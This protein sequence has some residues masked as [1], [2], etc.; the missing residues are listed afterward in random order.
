MPIEHARQRSLAQLIRTAQHARIG[1]LS[2]GIEPELQQH[3]ARHA[4]A[5]RTAH[6]CAMRQNCTGVYGNAGVV[7]NHLRRATQGEKPDRNAR[8]GDSQRCGDR[9]TG[10]KTGCRHRGLLQ[11]RLHS[12]RELA[13]FKK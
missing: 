3:I 12:Y 8:A 11:Q 1:D 5:T 13:F 6:R 10:G 4:G 9:N 2:F 7:R